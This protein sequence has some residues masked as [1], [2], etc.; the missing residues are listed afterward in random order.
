MWGC[1]CSVEWG[2]SLP[3]FWELLL[4]LSQFGRS[5]RRQAD[6]LLLCGKKVIF[7]RQVYTVSWQQAD[8]PV[9]WAILPEYYPGGWRAHSMDVHPSTIR[10]ALLADIHPRA[11]QYPKRDVWTRHG[12]YDVF[13]GRVG[14]HGMAWRHWEPTSHTPLHSPWLS[15]PPSRP[16]PSGPVLQGTLCF[17]SQYPSRCWQLPSGICSHLR[18]LQRE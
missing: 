1:E 14:S 4:M 6:I 7:D 12:V 10:A 16:H 15:L 9:I 8:M 13:S 18:P 11:I 5:G 2:Q 17:S 3:T